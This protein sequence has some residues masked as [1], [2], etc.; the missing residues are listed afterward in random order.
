MPAKPWW[1]SKT[2]WFNVLSLALAAVPGLGLNPLTITAIMGVGNLAL[3]YLTTQPIS[4][5]PTA[6]K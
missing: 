1:K 4:I 2:I 5:L 3:R 6:A